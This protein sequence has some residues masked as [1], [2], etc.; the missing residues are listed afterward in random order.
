MRSLVIW[1]ITKRL[2][3]SSNPGLRALIGWKPKQHSFFDGYL[4][5]P[6]PDSLGFREI[7]SNGIFSG[8]NNLHDSLGFREIYSNGIFYGGNNLHEETGVCKVGVFRA[9]STDAMSSEKVLDDEEE[10]EEEQYSQGSTVGLYKRISRL[11]DTKQSAVEV[12]EGWIRE[13]RRVK[14]AEIKRMVKELRKFYRYKHALEIFEWMGQNFSF[15]SGERAIHLDLIA[16]VH[17]ISSAE[18]YFANLPAIEKNHQTYSAILNCYVKEKNI[19]K[20]E[21]TMEKMKYLGFANNPLPY[22]EMMTLYMNMEQ[23]EKVPLV[24][25]GMKKKCISLDAYSYSI[26]MKSYAALSHMDRVEGVLIELELDDNIDPDWNIYSTVASIYIKAQVLDKAESAL[27]KLE[28]KMIEVEVK[29]KRK[30]RVAYDHL[31]S[32]YGSLGNKDEVYRIWQSYE[33]AFPMSTNRSYICLVSSLVRM[34][35][36]EGAEAF[37]KKWLSVKSFDDIRVSN[38]LLG[39]YTRQGYLQKAEVF[40]QH[41]MKNGGKPN[42]ITWEILAEGYIKSEQVHKAMEAMIRSLSVGQNHWQPKSENVL[43]I[44]RH[45]EKQGDV[46]SAEEFLKTLRGVKF[47]STEIYNSLLRTYLRVDKV[48]SRISELMMEDNVSP[49]EETGTLLKQKNEF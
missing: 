19:E 32:L 38:I 28:K 6:L 18:N 29:T 11:G 42:A 7:Y 25:Q 24:I 45:F 9:V 26:W 41:I 37:V 12:L 20:A 40:L 34:G 23:F 22:N 33:L 47:V 39:A 35:D 5:I 15:S 10:E 21:A 44:L 49:D 36:L 13:G 43:E 3:S 46:K 4:K 8:G 31:I 27:K 17:G 16:K 14:K 2:A 30:Y 48:P 1:A